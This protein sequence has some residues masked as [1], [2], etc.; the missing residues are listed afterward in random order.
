VVWPVAAPAQPGDG[1]RRLGV[2]MSL[3]ADD[4][5]GQA[6]AAA[7]VQGLGALKWHDG[8][9]LRI[10]WLLAIPCSSSD[11]RR[12]SP[13]PKPR[14]SWP[15][16]PRLSRRCDDEQDDPDRVRGCH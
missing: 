13:R 4:P 7:L 8:D 12:N 10:D 9:N 15:L 14:Y 1:I 5:E 11:T 3:R 16:A 6:Y 2:L